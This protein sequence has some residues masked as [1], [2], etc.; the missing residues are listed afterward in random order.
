MQPAGTTVV[1]GAKTTKWQIV[2]A[3]GSC[4]SVYIKVTTTFLRIV[5]SSCLGCAQVARL[6]SKLTPFEHPALFA[7]R[8]IRLCIPERA[9]E[10]HRPKVDL[11]EQGLRRGPPALAARQGLRN[12]SGKNQFKVSSF[13]HLPPQQHTQYHRSR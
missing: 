11:C 2:P 7:A 10:V 8:L 12:S 3:G 6:S 9:H 13:S 4:S 1:L 5:H